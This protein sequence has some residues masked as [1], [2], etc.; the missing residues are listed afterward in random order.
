[1]VLTADAG[2]PRMQRGLP[3]GGYRPPA[4]HTCDPELKIPIR[5]D[6][7]GLPGQ[8][9]ILVVQ[10]IYHSQIVHYSIAHQWRAT[11]DDDWRN[12][13]RIDTS[14]GSVHSHQ[15]R[16]DEGPEESTGR[17]RLIQTLGESDGRRVVD[18]S[19]EDS[20]DRVTQFMDEHWREW[21]QG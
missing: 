16:Q 1:M 4:K 18:A 2:R 7:E 5:M 11:P 12:V 8:T 20:Y 14:D 10:R 6:D 21:R 17:K 13:F 15:F 9:R 19:Y 3:D